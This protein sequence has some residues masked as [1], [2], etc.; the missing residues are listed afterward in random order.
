MWKFP[1]VHLT[2]STN[3]V[4]HVILSLDSGI[5]YF[6]ENFSKRATMLGNQPEHEIKIY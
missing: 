3:N 5:R 1:M 2:D 6:H 4:S